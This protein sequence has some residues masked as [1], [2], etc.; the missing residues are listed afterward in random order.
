MWKQRPLT[1]SPW[2]NWVPTATTA[3]LVL[4]AW[5]AAPSGTALADAGNLQQDV[6]ALQNVGNAGVYAQVYDNGQVTTARAGVARLDTVQPVPTDARYRTGSVTKT[7]VSATLLLLVGENRLAL[8]DTVDRWLPGVV[9]GNGNDGTQITV[10]QLLNHT[11]GLFDYTNDADFF[12]TVATPA[13]FAA[14]RYHHYAPADL[15]A[16]ALAHPPVFPP[17]T[18]WAY[19]NTNYILAGQVIQAV[20]GHTWDAE[21]TSR[22]IGPLGL[23]GTTAPG[24]AATMPGAYAQG[25]HI[26]TASPGSRVYTDTTEDNMSWAGSAGSLITTAGD[27]NR[28]FTALFSGQV[29]APA[30]FAAL[31]EVVPLGNGIGYGL[32]VVRQQLKCANTVVWWHNGGTVGYTTWAGTTSGGTLALALSL[33]TTTF[34]DNPYTTASNNL[35]DNVIRHVFCGSAGGGDH[36][37]QLR[38]A[39]FRGP[40]N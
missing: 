36:F 12:A 31:T 20:T 38:S 4:G 23:T 22:I 27:E 18:G 24:D 9:T 21:V 6:N 26:F 39:L 2:R 11:S 28:F 8:T 25:Y 32:G 40:L 3:A 35:T 15:I 14:N 34:T 13:A 19:S 37:Q 17:G 29:L 5:A 30:Q 1:R 33:S 7:F 16:I 10:R